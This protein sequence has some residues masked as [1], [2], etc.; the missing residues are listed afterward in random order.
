MVSTKVTFE[1]ILKAHER[2]KSS[3]HRT[4]IFQCS[5]LN[6]KS[7]N[8]NTRL[9]F[10][11][12]NLQKIGAFKIRGVMNALLQ[13]P[14]Q[15]FTTHSSGNHAQALALGCQLTDKKAIIVMPKDSPAVKVN[16]V[17]DTYGAE[18]HF[19]EPTQQSR[20]A[21]CNDILNK[22]ET[23]GIE[24]I[25]PFDDARIVCGNG[26]VAIE[27][28]EDVDTK[29]DAVIIAVGGG[30][31]LAGCVTAIRGMANMH[32]RY[33]GIKVIGAEPVMAN[34][35][36][37][38]FYTNEKLHKAVNETP[39]KTIADS[40]KTNLGGITFP[41]I[42][43]NVDAIIQVTEDEIKRAMRLT[44]ERTKLLIEPGAAVAVAAALSEE[45]SKKYPDCRN[46]GVVLCGGNID[47]STI[48]GVID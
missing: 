33:E 14:S 10:K 45:F 6:Q 31:L 8:E 47:L 21:A 38:S 20:E 40:L 11:A 46:V 25:H 12:E 19:C 41:I 13:S 16:A 7:E 35:C 26:T 5:L 9:F 28:L 1:N 2:I 23:D 27:L 48:S 34:D 4:S 44:I 32:S 15:L 22:Y 3:I 30:G 29:L 42:M 39:P 37:R 24:L 43:E 36:W 18:I 17:R